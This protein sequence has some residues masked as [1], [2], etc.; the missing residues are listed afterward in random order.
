[1]C[2]EWLYVYS[3]AFLIQKPLEQ[4]KLSVLD[5]KVSL[6]QRLLSTQMWHLGQV[7]VSCL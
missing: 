4:T 7:K 2:N 5:N 6:F 1:M 3:G